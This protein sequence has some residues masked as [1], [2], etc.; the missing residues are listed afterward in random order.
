MAPT[1][2][3]KRV[4]RA[5]AAAKTTDTTKDVPGR[6]ITASKVTK[7]TSTRETKTTTEEPIAQ[8]TEKPKKTSTRT[9]KATPLT[10]APRRR[11]KVTPLDASPAVDEPAPEPTKETV[12]PKKTTTKAKKTTKAS[13]QEEKKE[14]E[15]QP[16]TRA[17]STKTV[18]KKA[19]KEEP[20]PKTRGRP[21]RGAVSQ[22]EAEIE[23]TVDEPAPKTRQTRA[24]STS[25]AEPPIDT[26][27]A[28]AKPKT[29][30]RKKVTF[31]Q[32]P[33]DDKENQPVPTRKTAAKKQ[34]APATGIRA[35]PI[36]KPAT[37]TT[38][39]A[40]IA[41]KSRVTKAP[42]RALTPKKVSQVN[43]QSTP[44][45]SDGEDE[46]SGAKTP[47]RDLSMSP[48]RNLQLGARL[49][50]V[51]K[52]DFTQTLKSQTQNSSAEPALLFSPARRP[53]SPS[54]K[55]L[56][57]SP[58]K[59][60][61][62]RVEVPPVFPSNG[63]QSIN[64]A[65]TFAPSSLSQSVL[66]QSPKRVAL[67][68]NVFS[69]SAMKPRTS[70]LKTSLLQSPARRL[71]SPAKRRT[72]GA[73]EKQFN[74]ATPEDVVISSQFRASVSPKRSVGVHRMS[75]EELAEEMKD[76]IDFD[77]SILDVRSPMKIQQ[78][79]SISQDPHDTNVPTIEKDAGAVSLA[80][81]DEPMTDESVEVED[82]TK[83]QV[84]SEHEE[85]RE[86]NEQTLDNNAEQQAP[87]FE[88][89]A[90]DESTIIVSQ[91]RP[92]VSGPR[93]SE[94]LFR[95]TRFR[96]EDESSED[97]LAA[98]MTP[99]RAPRLFRSSLN[100]A[101]TRSRLSTVAPSNFS[102]NVGFTPLAAQMS[103]WLAASPE[104]KSVKK[105]QSEGVF[106]PVAAQHIDGEVQ[107][108][109]QS[110]PQ[111]HR[112]P[113]ARS[114]MSSARS[115]QS[116]ASLALSMGASPAKTSFF[117]EQ[118][119]AQDVDEQMVDVSD[120]LPPSAELATIAPEKEVGATEDEALNVADRRAGDATEDQDDTIVLEPENGELI[121]DLI[122]FTNASDTAMVD[123]A[124]LAEEAE[125]LAPSGSDIQQSSS[126]HSIYGDE[127]ANPLDD[128]AVQEDPVE[129]QSLEAGAIDTADAFEEEDGQVERD[130]S[131]VLLH[132]ESEG[133]LPTD[134]TIE[135]PATLKFNSIEMVTPVR[136]D[137]SLPRF[138]NTVVSKI[139][140]RPEGDISPIKIT[141][142]RSRSLST[143]GNQ[144]PP[145]RPQ[146]TPV[147]KLAAR[148]ISDNSFS[149]DRS[150]R[151]AAPSPAH[152]TPGQM[153]FAVD[154]FGDS[155][156]D[157]IKLPEDE[158]D[159]DVGPPTAT[160]T[161][162]ATKSVKTVE[163][164][165]P[166]PGRTPLK[167]VGR[168]VLHG[169]VVYVEVHT[170]EGADASGVYVDLL[171]QM[172]A[173]CIRDWRWNPRASINAGEDPAKIGITHVV[174][175][176]GGRRTLEKVRDAKG[177]VWCVGVRWV[178]E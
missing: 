109:R 6:K 147:G 2:P 174:Y 44:D 10:A 56:L 12:R 77:Q 21:K 134:K 30:V 17:R 150:L 19:E 78:L 49:S 100:G 88:H 80:D 82:S 101:G 138:V 173:R 127:N 89:A 92:A 45:A 46:L 58:L 67:D 15:A 168:G 139:P 133:Q 11:I 83:D 149:P 163:S 61:P 148:S 120:A 55:V 123:F 51:K 117:E 14:P 158:M 164:P 91:T 35:K 157:G 130:A 41:S 111:H 13:E 146:L 16:K 131:P 176:D 129:I 48:K 93:L 108:S 106:S 172:G 132:Q 140:L 74:A 105:Q 79:N 25:T 50:P 1:S 60:S 126:E 94:V 40:S 175:K 162:A 28:T 144:S 26:A 166:T 9:A 122:N 98:D 136:P 104:K 85:G 20:V 43:R 38:K 167:S 177:E 87:Q 70:P 36:R 22:P 34:T 90:E 57:Q 102:R 153:S 71:F 113:L 8:E 39:K 99:D 69:L 97:E 4:T 37:T 154:D 86:S 7:A 124:N 53:T 5:R 3:L 135:S 47:I 155:T 141:K 59:E 64:V 119:V 143:A 95:S 107:I 72:P 75:D 54:K 115:A 68:S 145:K 103:G 52:L 118:M 32:L 178:L 128:R 63:Q 18:E 112:S 65:A 84:D 33:E 23:E 31:Q 125:Y 161:P 137:P 170:T 156:L 29:G 116:R 96:E 159:F 165:V 171:T 142:K 42:P 27:T 151:S 81:D 62:R 66:L 76:A 160:A 169:A 121:T 114:Q 24:R 110:T 152:T 73:S